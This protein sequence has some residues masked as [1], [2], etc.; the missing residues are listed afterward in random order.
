MGVLDNIK[1]TPRYWKKA[2]QELFA[3]LENLG[4]FTFFFTLS[5]ADMRWAENFTS[6]LEGHRVTFTSIDGQEDFFIDDTPLDEFLKAY[7]SKHEL[8]KT[9]LPN[10]TL[11]F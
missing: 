2:R 11:N 6:L 10:A 3:K 5:C 1:N 4:P 7:P 9:N 8:I